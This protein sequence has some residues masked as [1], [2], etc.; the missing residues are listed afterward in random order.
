M[1]PGYSGPILFMK[2]FFARPARIQFQFL[3][4]SYTDLFLR[5]VFQQ[6]FQLGHEFLHVLKI[7]ID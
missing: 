2:L 1:G 6:T 3:I 5:P 4:R 7:Q